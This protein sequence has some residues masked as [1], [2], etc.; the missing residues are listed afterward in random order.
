M[1]AYERLDFTS[2]N[3]RPSRSYYIPGGV[4]EYHLLN[5]EWNFAYFDRD[6][7]V[8]EKIEKWDK[9]PVPSCWQLH[10]YENP[11][12]TNINYP[13]PCDPPYVP[14]DNPCGVYEREFEIE[15]KWGRLYFVFEGVASCAYLTINDKYVGFTQGSHLQAEFDI[16]DYVCE[17]TNKVTVKVLKWCCGSYL[18]DQDCFRFNGIF[19]DCYVLQRPE[20]HIDDIDMIPN[21]KEINVKLAGQAQVSIYK[22]EE[23][24]VSTQMEDT[25]TY[26][27]E[28]PVLWNAE[29]PFLY[30]VV[31]ER[32]GEVITLKA[33]L[34]KLEFQ[35]NLSF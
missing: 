25:F 9:I 23:L 3:R 19:R 14:D 15:K 16:T 18:E 24:L 13:Y 33:G 34:V 35:T 7:D 6:I 20:N 21:D 22:G 30:K 28:N 10:G 2:E 11:N 8:P 1:R 12:Y 17:G 4:S 5:G 29:K 27:V 32:A 31:F 26:A